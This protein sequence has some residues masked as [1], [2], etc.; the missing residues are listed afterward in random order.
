MTSLD[1]AVKSVLST[2]KKSAKPLAVILAGH[3]GSG[4]STLWYERLSGQ[5][6]I[7]LVNADRM[8]LS[9]LPE[10]RPLPGW[11]STLRDKNASWMGVAQRGVQAFVAQ[12]MALKV[13]FAMETVF[14]HWRQLENGEIESKLDLIRQLQEAGYF[15]LL[16][17]V[18][19]ASADLSEARV[20]TRVTT[21]GHS[22]PSEKLRE[23]FPRTQRAIA[24]AA[25]VA[26]AT[27]MIDNSL[28]LDRAFTVC[29]VQLHDQ[30][31]YDC[32]EEPTGPS[33]AVLQWLEKVSPR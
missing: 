14:S 18:G 12:A 23:R 2:H 31:R 15:V 9:I 33:Q 1:D 5:F 24:E 32:R 27:V 20:L 10:T 19:L 11:A 26:D 28:T 22:V 16:L 4:K 21:G 30:T 7:P 8:M 17:F 25:Q 6:Q 29:R 3:N 13:P